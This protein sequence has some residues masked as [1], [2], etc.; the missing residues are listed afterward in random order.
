MR[1]HDDD[2]IPTLLTPISVEQQAEFHGEHDIRVLKDG[3]ILHTRRPVA[4]RRTPGTHGAI[5]TR[6]V[7]LVEAEAV[8]A[9][10]SHQRPR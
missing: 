9:S 10:R 3:R 5:L 6:S 2:H 1:L 8:T 4:M 7:G